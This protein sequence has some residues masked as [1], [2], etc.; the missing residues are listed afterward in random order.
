MARVEIR[1]SLGLAVLGL[2]L[3]ASVGCSDSALQA[4]HDATAD[5]Q[6]GDDGGGID[7]DDT[8]F[9]DDDS[10][11]VED[12]PGFDDDDSTGDD[13][14]PWLD[15]C[16]D[17]A[18]PITGFAAPDGGD[19]IHVFSWGPTWMN[20]T[21][22]APVSGRFAVYDSGVYESGPSQTNESAYLRIRNPDNPDGVPED[23]TCEAEHVVVDGDNDGPP[24][25]P[26]TYLGTFPLVQG[27]N[28]LTLH[29][30]CPLFRAG[31]CEALHV[32]EP[33][34]H[35][36]CDDGGLNSV[37]LVAAGICLVPRPR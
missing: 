34:A 36:G 14:P 27:D 26:L 31:R 22:T 21:L 1:G 30:Y 37:H 7:D 11:L 5:T 35:S 28:D 2:L 6:D 3:A 16:P 18:V 23:P 17:D 29:H 4:L 13:P 25:A 19:E 8:A 15:A 20:A 10:G 9:D 33:P 24:P 32:G 12:D